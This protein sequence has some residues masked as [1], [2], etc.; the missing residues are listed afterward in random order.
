[1]ADTDPVVDPT[2]DDEIEEDIPEPVSHQVTDTVLDLWGSRSRPCRVRSNFCPF[3]GA[4]L[5]GLRWVPGREHG[6][7]KSGRQGGPPVKAHQ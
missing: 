4:W 7:Y 2:V 6:I 5:A 1:M 3:S